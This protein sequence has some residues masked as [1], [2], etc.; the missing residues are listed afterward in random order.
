MGGLKNDIIELSPPGREGQLVCSHSVKMSAIIGPSYTERSRRTQPVWA[1]C[2]TN[3]DYEPAV[4][5]II[6]IMF[7][8]FVK[9][10]AESDE[11]KFEQFICIIFHNIVIGY[12][13]KSTHLNI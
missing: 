11:M 10:E 9:E 12:Q 4:I 3:R 5:R 8:T 7:Q 2:F 1:A 13:L 6:G